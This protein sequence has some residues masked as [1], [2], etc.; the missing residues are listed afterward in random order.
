M[1]SSDPPRLPLHRDPEVMRVCKPLIDGLTDAD[2]SRRLR[3]SAAVAAMPVGV[4]VH[5]A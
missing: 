1:R 3:S 4:R 2:E 5:I